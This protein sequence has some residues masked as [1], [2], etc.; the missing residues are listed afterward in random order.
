VEVV[1][2]C[3]KFVD[4]RPEIDPV[5]GH[6]VPSSR[7]GGFSPADEAALE[8]ALRLAE[9]WG[10]ECVLVCAGPPQAEGTLAALGAAG[11]ARVVRIDHSTEQDSSLTADVLAPVLGAGDLGAGVVVCG[12]LS[13]D[14]GSGAVPALLAH[15]LDA[16][17]ALGLIELDV[18]ANGAVRAVRRL[19][20]GRR[21]VLEVAPPCVLS[22][23]G[24]AA[25]LRRA[26]LGPSMDSAGSPRLERR[27][28]RLEGHVEPPRLRPWRPRA[29][30]LPAPAG[31]TAFERVVALTGALVDRTPP[32]TVEAEPADA[33]R[34][35][36]DQLV[37]WGYLEPLPRAATLDL[38]PNGSADERHGAPR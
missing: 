24:A 14:R 34:L 13:Y 31:G 30:V 4:L 3:V 38:D 1:A 16:G 37:A 19:D 32:R 35:L 6:L 20:G 29:R 33:A 28:R 26:P 18:G 2:A 10:A 12:D 21:E 9:H 25:T 8:T 7:G 22:V 23:E 27:H 36:L 11:A 17:Q 5:H 15:H